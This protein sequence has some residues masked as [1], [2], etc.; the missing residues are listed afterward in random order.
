MSEGQDLENVLEQH[1]FWHR[2]A[3]IGRISSFS[4]TV[5]TAIGGV[6]T[7]DK[8]IKGQDATGEVVTGIS[9]LVACAI[10]YAASRKAD[11]HA[12]ELEQSVHTISS[13]QQ[14]QTVL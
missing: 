3:T 14:G 13:G 12:Q 2:W 1:A 4:G 11:D 6:G 7:T 8:L 10:I 5:M 9:S